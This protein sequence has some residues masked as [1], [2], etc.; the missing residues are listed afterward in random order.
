MRF[1]ARLLITFAPEFPVARNNFKQ[2]LGS[3]AVITPALG[4]RAILLGQLLGERPAIGVDRATAITV[5]A[6]QVAERAQ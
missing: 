3:R 4:I 5:A 6:E 1:M 2:K